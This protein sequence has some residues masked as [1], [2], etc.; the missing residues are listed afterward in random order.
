M[1]S[2]ASRSDA[3][4]VHG[5]EDGGKRWGAL[6]CPSQ[7]GASFGVQLV[8][9]ESLRVCVCVYVCVHVC[10]LRRRKK[11][12]AQAHGGSSRVRTACM[13]LGKGGVRRRVGH[14]QL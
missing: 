5:W 4:S 2:I 11:R 10:V 13:P 7:H 3:L 8:K 14:V 9:S 1:W 12:A 6:W